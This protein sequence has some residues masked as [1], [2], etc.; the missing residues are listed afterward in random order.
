MINLIKLKEI[1]EAM[2]KGFLKKIALQADVHYQTVVSYFNG[3]SE[4]EKVTQA[5]IELCKQHE[6]QVKE[7]NSI[8]TKTR[9]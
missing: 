6:A 8:K 4:N 3:K 5:V 9:K 7:L 2:P 1:K